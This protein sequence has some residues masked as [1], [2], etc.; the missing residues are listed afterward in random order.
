MILT[1]TT[2]GVGLEDGR[3]LAEGDLVETEIEG[4]GTLRNRVG[5]HGALG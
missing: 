1:G 2:C 3:F 5:P 4:I